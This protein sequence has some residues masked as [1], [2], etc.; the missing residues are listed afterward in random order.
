MLTL[1]SY[2]ACSLNP[3]SFIHECPII[4][5]PLAERESQPPFKAAVSSG[6]NIM[7]EEDS[8]TS[9]ALTQTS[10]STMYATV[11]MTIALKSESRPGPKGFFF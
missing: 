6:L 1:L 3:D 10:I 5:A 9:V 8:E 7:G 11:S 2:E 4:P